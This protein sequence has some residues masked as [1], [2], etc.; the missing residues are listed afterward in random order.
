MA[1]ALESFTTAGAY[2]SDEE[3]LKG[4]IK[5]GMLAD[6]TVLGADLFETDPYELY[7]IPV[8]ETWLGGKRVY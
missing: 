3:D 2:A 8:L 1:E 4:Q 7:A 6:F 5:E